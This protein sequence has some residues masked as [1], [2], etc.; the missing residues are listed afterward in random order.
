MTETL[1]NLLLPGIGAFTLVDSAYV[2]D[3]DIQTNFMIPGDAI[4]KPRGRVLVDQMAKLNPDVLDHVWLEDLPKDFSPYDIVVSHTF[5][6]SPTIRSLVVVESRGFY[7]RVSLFLNAPHLVL[8]SENNTVPDYRIFNPWTELRAFTN[9][10]CVHSMDVSHVPFLLQLIKAV[11]LAGLR[12]GLRRDELVQQLGGDSKASEEAV[13]HTYLVTALE[14]D[15][16][17]VDRLHAIR[18]SL[19]Q[20][21]NPLISDTLRVIEAVLRFYST[22]K[23]LPLAIHSLPDMTSYTATYTEL[24]KLYRDKR[25]RDSASVVSIMRHLSPE[26]DVDV[27]FVDSVIKN[28]RDI[29]LLDPKADSGEEEEI[30][31]EFDEL[32]A[33]MDGVPQEP[34]T[35]L[36]QD[37]ARTCHELH[38]TS[39]SIGAVAA[40]EM[41]KLLTHHFCPIE[42][43][44]V[45]NGAYGTNAV[46]VRKRR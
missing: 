44:F 39:A 14:R 12:D 9:R 16:A 31:P 30:S 41:I 8:S 5:M 35:P 18:D 11:E 42:N 13:K 45:L 40:Q 1:K 20:S 22:E 3:A 33:L 29:H 32:I 36:A 24:C 25:D 21:A 15:A 27:A 38:T 43:S 37:Y 26:R 4:G 10:I 19:N 17:V 46:V 23:V 28:L 7:G 6:D 2:S 34:L